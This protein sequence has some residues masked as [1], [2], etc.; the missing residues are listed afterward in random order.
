[1]KVRFGLV[2]KLSAVVAAILAGAIALSGYFSNLISA[3]YSLESARAFLRFNSESITEGIGRFMMTRNTAG[4]EELILRMSRNSQVYGDIRL[5]AHPSGEVVAS[6]LEGR[7]RRIEREDRTCAVCH[8]REDLGG[9]DAGP[10]DAVFDRPEGGRDLS[11]MTPIRNEP[12]CRTAACHV[13]AESP[14]ILGFLHVDYSLERMDATVTD[15]RILIAITVLASLL[16][17]L[18][19]LW[20]TFA[21]LLEKPIAGLVAGTERIAANQLDFRF[22]AKRSDEIGIL[23]ESFNT[24]TARVRAHRDE[25]RSGMEYLGGIVENT[26]ALIITLT[27]EGYIETFNRGAEQT[28]GRSR[29][30][31]IGRDFGTLFVDPGERDI[32]MSRLKDADHVTNFE[33][34]LLGKD[35]E[36]CYVLLTLSHLRDGDGQP[37]GTLGIG[38]DF[39]EEKKLLRELVQSQ[40]FAAIGQ[41]ATGIQHAVKNLLNSLKGGQYLVRRGLAGND[42]EQIREGWAMAE[43]G[44][45][46]ITD[47]SR[48]ML[49]YAK[50]WKPEF[51]RADLSDLLSGLCEL[52]RQAAADRG[53]ALRGE[54]PEGLPAVLCDPE[55]IH[56]AV[57]DIVANAID[58]CAEKQ[59]GIGESPEVVLRNSLTEGGEVFMIEACDN[60]CG[61][62]DEIRRNIF[63]PFFSTKNVR[64]TG[65]GLALTARVIDA[66]GGRISV[67]SDP[68]R[69]TTFRIQLPTDG[70]RDDKETTDGQT[71][72]RS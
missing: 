37:M 70:P 36:V 51:R 33:T 64:G 66:H 6:R 12:G 4:V 49:H 3:H 45:E 62:N 24:M 38:K 35:G 32:A 60:G 27:P 18:A 67:E 59:Y 72:S 50:E 63:A 31:V 68:G 56:I 10:V 71:S 22:A 54:M 30:E 19:A 14:P 44:I 7:G 41:A 28:L 29:V 26:A 1:M 42:Q 2:W 17:G 21:R 43:E 47:L 8:D 48:N 40:R 46:R 57:T 39:T 15:R 55:L 52:N 65:L 53:V 69:G 25:L 20:S 11:I 16:L 13:H 61:M 23:E 58:A 9:E 34:G 5:V